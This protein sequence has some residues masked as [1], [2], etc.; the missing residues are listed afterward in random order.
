MSQHCPPK[1]A[2]VSLH[3]LSDRPCVKRTRPCMQRARPGKQRA[4]PCFGIR[5]ARLYMRC[6]AWSARGQECA[7]RHPARSPRHLHPARGPAL[8]SSARCPA[9]SARCPASMRAECRSEMHDRHLAQCFF[10]SY[11][12]K[13]KAKM[14]AST[15]TNSDR[16]MSGA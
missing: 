6:P 1:R 9:S 15:I 5:R 11:S 8:A 14:S 12:S 2:Y 7:A 13:T 16:Q 10:F 3:V 4:R